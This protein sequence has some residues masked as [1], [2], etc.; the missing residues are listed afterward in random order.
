[1]LHNTEADDNI[2]KTDVRTPTLNPHVKLAVIVFFA[3]AGAFLAFFYNDNGP[4]ILVHTFVGTIVGA[5][6][7]IMLNMF[8]E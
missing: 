4:G 8:A 7:G 6:V 3:V 1:M 2:D 5:F